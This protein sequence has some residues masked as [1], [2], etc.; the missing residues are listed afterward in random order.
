MKQ[1]I[2]FCHFLLSIKCCLQI[3]QWSESVLCKYL[4]ENTIYTF[5]NT[6]TITF[7]LQQ[8][9]D[10]NFEDSFYKANIYWVSPLY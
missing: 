1:D 2:A 7:Q 3:Q 8:K 5:Y 4:K 6:R 10:T 9:N